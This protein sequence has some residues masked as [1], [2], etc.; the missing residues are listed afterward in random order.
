M[1]WCFMVALLL[2]LVIVAAFALVL[3]FVNILGLG[4]R[5]GP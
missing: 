4:T 3:F 5:K 2:L 1:R